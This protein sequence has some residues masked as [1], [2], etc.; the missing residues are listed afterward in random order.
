MGQFYKR[1]IIYA[2]DKLE[3]NQADIREFFKIVIEE[4]KNQ[5][6]EV[7]NECAGKVLLLHLDVSS[8][9]DPD[10][11]DQLFNNHLRLRVA[12]GQ[13]DDAYLATREKYYSGA[14]YHL[15]VCRAYGISLLEELAKDE[16]E[17]KSIHDK[18]KII[19]ADNLNRVFAEKGA[20]P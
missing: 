10:R 6:E 14:I 15:R 1:N 5:C 12:Y 20:Q 4:Y 3:K 7:L 2:R 17:K 8:R 16:N 13:L 19:K 9:I 18:Y 11:S